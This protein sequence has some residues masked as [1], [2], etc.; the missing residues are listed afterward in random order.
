MGDFTRLRVW[1][2]AHALMLNANRVATGIR[3]PWQ[4]L[5]SQ[6]IRAAMSIPANIVE[7]R[8]QASERE[9]ARFLGFSLASTRE[10]DYHL[11]AARDMGAI[12]DADYE[13]LTAQSA[14]VRKML[15][16]LLRKLN[17]SS[18]RSPS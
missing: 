12:N 11:L 8:A 7:G 18:S 4:S 17:G 13:Q 15:H 16:G 5:R 3:A 2:N 1:R 9:F 14:D 6:T 10:L